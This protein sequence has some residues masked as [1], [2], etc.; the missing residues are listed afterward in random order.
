MKRVEAYVSSEKSEAVLS[1]LES[2]NF[3]ATFFESKG[4]GKGEKRELSF[5]GRTM[6]MRYSTRNT[7]V[8]IVDEDKLD[9]VISI[10][11]GSGTTGTTSSGVIV[12]SPV[13]NLITL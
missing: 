11:K 1:A 4:M 3:Q 12:I 9:Q 10:I 5:K 2:S 8:T 13:D 7:I 6:K